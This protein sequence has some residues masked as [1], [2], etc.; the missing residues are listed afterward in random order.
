M[1]VLFSSCLLNVVF[2]IINLL[3]HRSCLLFLNQ[4]R[5]IKEIV[6]KAMG[7]AISKSVAVAEIIKVIL[8][9]CSLMFATLYATI[10]DSFLENRKESLSCIKIPTSALSASLM[11]GNLLKKALSR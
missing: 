1:Q 4:D 10:S 2:S 6:L 11:C 7:Q 8:H 5:R 3:F 9:F